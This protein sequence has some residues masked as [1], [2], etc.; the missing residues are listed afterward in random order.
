MEPHIEDEQLLFDVYE[1]N[2]RFINMCLGLYN[3]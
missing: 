1:K 3:R 2:L